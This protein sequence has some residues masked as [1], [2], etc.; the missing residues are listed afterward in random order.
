[1]KLATYR[2]NGAERVGIVHANDTKVFDL[3]T[4][5]ERS[6]AAGGSAT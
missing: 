1:M 5:A 4:A 2:K 6:G 3:A